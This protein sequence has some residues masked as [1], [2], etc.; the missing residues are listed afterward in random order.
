MF[1]Q[2]KVICYFVG[3]YENETSRDPSKEEEKPPFNDTMIFVEDYLRNVVAHSWAFT[4]GQQNLLTFQVSL[5]R[6]A[7]MVSN[8][9]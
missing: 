7:L 5:M 8:T 6:W 9:S 2:L 1:V 3:R 4:D